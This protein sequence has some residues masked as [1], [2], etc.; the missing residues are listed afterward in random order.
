MIQHYPLSSS[1]IAN[2]NHFSFLAGLCGKK[3]HPTSVFLRTSALFGVKYLS[4]PVYFGLAGV[5]QN[6]GLPAL[7]FAELETL[8]VSLAELQM[9]IALGEAAA[10]PKLT[11]VNPYEHNTDEDSPCIILSSCANL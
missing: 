9:N 3:H 2:C 7:S 4:V 1:N 6:L 5:E 8:D 11:R 10:K